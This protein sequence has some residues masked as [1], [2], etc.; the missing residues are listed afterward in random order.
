MLFSPSLSSS[1]S[2]DNNPSKNTA[3][4]KHLE[5]LLNLQH[6]ELSSLSRDGFFEVIELVILE[7]YINNKELV[8]LLWHFDG[9]DSDSYETNEKVRKEVR[10]FVKEMRRKWHCGFEGEMGVRIIPGGEMRF[11]V[12][13][14]YWK[15]IP[16]SAVATTTTTTSSSSSSSSSRSSSSS[17]TTLYKYYLITIWEG[18][19]ITTG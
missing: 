1:L 8:R 9:I 19:T 4:R 14:G 5:K 3:Q 10:A 13:G 6:Q 7:C 18:S 11:V 2:S 12:E 16:I 15:L 17:S